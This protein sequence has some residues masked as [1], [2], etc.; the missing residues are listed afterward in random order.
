MQIVLDKNG[1]VP[2]YRQLVRQLRD[3]IT[4]GR[5]AAHYRL[6]SERNL[7]AQLGINRTTVLQAYRQLRDE[8]FIASHV[9]KGTFVQDR[10]QAA[11][12]ITHNPPWP[13]LFSDYSNR[14]T[15]HDLASANQAQ[16]LTGVI[17]F[18]TGSPNP[19]AIPDELLRQVSLKAFASHD[20]DGQ[21]ESPIEGFPELRELLARHMRRDR[22]IRCEPGN[23]MVL[24][25][26]EQGIDLCVRAFINPGDCILVEQY[27]F[28]PA[29]Q[30]FR[31]AG[32]RVVAVPLDGNGMRTDLLDA[33][34]TRFHPKLIYTIPTFHNPTGTTMPADRRCTLL[35]TAMRNQCLILEDDPYGELA[36]ATGGMG[37]RDIANPVVTPLKGME[38]SGYV[39]YLSTFSKT[40]APGLRTGWLIADTHVVSRLAALRT[41]VDQHTS[42]SSQRICIQLLRAN[43]VSEHVKRL[44][45]DNAK[46]L[47]AFCTAM[48]RYAKN[49]LL[50][51]RPAGGYYVWASLPPGMH[52]ETVLNAARR[53]GVSFMPGCIFDA[54]GDDDS[55]VRLN[56]IRPEL[57]EIDPGVR[58]LVASLEDVQE[59]G[60]SDRT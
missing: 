48:A 59:S 1:A 8:G 18:A 49:R 54:D 3:Q 29:L 27:T 25:G 28:F 2:L 10:A 24:S 57:A 5:L 43:L 58:R 45:D 4:E 9:G 47:E 37:N 36:Y 35:E 42:S 34:C 44:R 12:P 33:Y 51:S 22:A 26:S 23:I 55:H 32:A 56:F 39:V 53:R 11:P 6:P 19:Q 60:C 17:D 30:A 20:F 14:F 38:N 46:K 40:V 52:G 50:W 13:L 41:L 16:N 15:Y 7:A 31:S 21:P